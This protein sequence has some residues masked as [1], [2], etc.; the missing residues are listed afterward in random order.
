MQGV[1]CSIQIT[2]NIPPTIT[3]YTLIV[4]ILFPIKL[5]WCPMLNDGNKTQN[6]IISYIQN[7]QFKFKGRRKHQLKLT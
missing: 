7:V 5:E 3:F 4:V 6:A 2:N 1:T